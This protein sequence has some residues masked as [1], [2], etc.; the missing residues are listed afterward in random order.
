M[1]R[2]NKLKKLRRKAI[3][4]DLVFYKRRFRV[5]DARANGEERPRLKFLHDKLVAADKQTTKAMIR[6]QLYKAKEL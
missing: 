3:K 4:W 1:S 6:Y 5:A 2:K